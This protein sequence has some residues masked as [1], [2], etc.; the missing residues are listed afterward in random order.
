M[1]LTS[2][3]FVAITCVLYSVKYLDTADSIYVLSLLWGSRQRKVFE[4]F[5][6]VPC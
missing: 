4:V 3:I 1:W 6:Y 2:H 5:Y